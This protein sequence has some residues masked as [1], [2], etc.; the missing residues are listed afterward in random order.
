MYDDRRG[1]LLQAP[2]P[3]TVGCPWTGKPVAISEYLTRYKLE[4]FLGRLTRIRHADGFVL[5][6]TGQ[7]SKRTGSAS[8][9]A[10]CSV[11][12]RRVARVATAKWRG[13]ASENLRPARA[14][15]SISGRQR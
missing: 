15:S 8:T 6:G 14:L 3:S 12:A 7:R 5:I 2:G 9:A 4:S 13:R 1:Y 10:A 11:S